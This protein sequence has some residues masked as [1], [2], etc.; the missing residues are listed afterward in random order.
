RSDLAFLIL[1]KLPNRVCRVSGISEWFR[2]TVARR[3]FRCVFKDGVGANF[4][5]H[6]KSLLPR[7]V[8][9]L[10]EAPQRC[11]LY[12]SWESLLAQSRVWRDLLNR[13]SIFELH[14]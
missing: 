1:L 12:G 14:C 8:R 9:R 3:F 2:R 7:F 11:H 6:R 4:K 5:T 13:S 10:E